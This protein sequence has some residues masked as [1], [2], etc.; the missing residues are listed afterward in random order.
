MHIPYSA[1]EV[2]CRS[3]YFRQAIKLLRPPFAASSERP[4][5]SPSTFYSR[6]VPSAPTY[7]RN[8]AYS[9]I[10]FLAHS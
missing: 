5:K 2:R 4:S 9:T 10:D 3:I 7:K 8:A 1:W 6:T